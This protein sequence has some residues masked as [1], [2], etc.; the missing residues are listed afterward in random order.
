MAEAVGCNPSPPFPV[1]CSCRYSTWV[2][3]TYFRML[4]LHN[5]RVLSLDLIE[6]LLDSLHTVPENITTQQLC[7]HGQL[8]QNQTRGHGCHCLQFSLI[9][10]QRSS[11]FLHNSL[12]FQFTLLHS[13]DSGNEITAAGLRSLWI[14]FGGFVFLGLV[15]HVYFNNAGLHFFKNCPWIR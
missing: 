9:R 11:I 6:C 2:L 3:P 10:T 8:L 15:S 13:P 4:V 1:W 7:T 12:T 5:V 14:A